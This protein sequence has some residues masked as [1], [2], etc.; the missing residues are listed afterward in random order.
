MEKTKIIAHRG[1]KGTHPEN[2]LIAFEE[3]IRVGSDGIELDVHLTKDS[4][5]VVIHDETVNRT[6]DGK[7]LVRDFSLEE[8]K[9]LDMGSWFDSACRICTIPTLQEVVELLNKHS[10]KGLLNIEFK[11]NKYPYPSIEKKVLEILS[12]QSNSF[13]IVFSSFNYQTLIRLKKI[14]DKV[15]IALLF[16]G[17]G[18]NKMMLDQDVPIE[19]WHSDLKWFKN[20]YLSEGFKIPIRLWTINNEEDLAYCFDKKV[21]G[22]FTDFPEKALTIQKKRQPIRPKLIAIVGPTA[23]GKTSLSIEL[24]KEYNGEIISGD[25]MQ[26]YKKLD[27]GTAKVSL[28]EQDGIVHHLI[29]EVSVNSRYSV[30]DF[31]KKGRQLIYDSIARGKTPII[32][33]GTGLYI[34]SILYNVSLGGTGESDLDFRARKEYEAQKS[35]V[36]HLWNELEKID[37]V[38]A[39]MIHANNVRRVI[40]ALEVHH[41]TGIP[42]SDYQEERE[43]KELLFDVKIIGLTTERSILYNRINQRVHKMMEQGLESEARW[44]YEQNIQDSQAMRGIGYKEWLPYFEN[45]GTIEDV[46][47]EIQKNSRRYAKRQL[48]WF[49]NRTKNVSWW[50]LVNEPESKAKLKQEIDCFLI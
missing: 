47:T 28:V 35:G 16:K 27:I 37:P 6:S 14:E 10:F 42:F 1:S 38:S 43:E 26:I 25:S 49:R 39:K 24:A 20:T 32:V 45:E 40:R 29:D 13:S 4:K 23:V 7:G 21:A 8:L 48:T 34:E 3:A 18:K 33:G 17:T 46:I 41:T 22:I 15:Q 5:V 12:K 50:D 36:Q 11:T 31:Q 9:R 19:M 44:L 2:T 30:S